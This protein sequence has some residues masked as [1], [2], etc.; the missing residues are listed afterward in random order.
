MPSRNTIAAKLA[1]IVC[2]AIIGA[3]TPA[4]ADQSNPAFARVGGYTSIPI[5]HSEF[6]KSNHD[7]CRGYPR[8]VEFETLTDRNWAQLVAINDRMNRDIVP[9]TD[10]DLYGVE[11]LWAYP[12]GFGDCEDIAL[13]KR[14]ALIEAGWNP[15]TLLMSVVRQPN[16]EGHAVLMAR[17]DRGDLI[18]DNQDGSV[19]LWSDTPYQ[20]LKRQS[21]A[22]P[23][24]WVDILDN[25]VIAVAQR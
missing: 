17:T 24:S 9:V 18:L 16:G 21:Q 4:F 20:F 10:T 2:L 11:E 7:D 23:A 14:R 25:R 8:S 1:T 5:G 6:C 19:R 12:D 22:N 3:A 15:S 13:A